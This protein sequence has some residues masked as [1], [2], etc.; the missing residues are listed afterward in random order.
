MERESRIRVVQK[1]YLTVA[2]ILAL[3]LLSGCAQNLAHSIA[4][5]D[6]PSFA[7]S[8]AGL[9]PVAPGYGRV[10]IYWEK[11]PML[12]AMGRFHLQGDAGHLTLAYASQTGTV[13]DLPA[14]NYSLSS[15]GKLNKSEANFAVRDGE[16]ACYSTDTL[17]N[18]FTGSMS[19]ELTP[20]QTQ[21]CVSEL[22]EKDIRCNLKSCQVLS[23]IPAM[24]S[25]FVRYAP[26][27]SD[28][29]LEQAAK[30][31]DT[32]VDRSRIY[33]TRKRYTLGMIK[34][35]LDGKPNMS[36]ESSSFVCYDV[37]PGFHVITIDDPNGKAGFAV[38]TKGGENL[39]FHSDTLDFLTIAEGKERVNDYDLLKDGFYRSAF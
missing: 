14:G 30:S 27:S 4:I 2:L 18:L 31:F 33:I 1:S 19:G 12:P 13:I 8:Y 32:P 28:K 10:I 15:G 36:M 5:R 21:A 3:A 26:E 39:F 25:Q 17:Y 7:S 9:V 11:K 16:I 22:A 34:S 6:I 20:V 23:V 24:D 35:G 29:Q 38:N 37:E